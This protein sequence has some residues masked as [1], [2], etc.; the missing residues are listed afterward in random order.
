MITSLSLGDRIA[1]AD[2]EAARL[3]AMANEMR[4]R[5]NLMQFDGLM[6]A[7]ERWR[8]LATELRG[9]TR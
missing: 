4:A 1:A 3:L 8:D 6:Q 2:A 5:G 7:H 9:G